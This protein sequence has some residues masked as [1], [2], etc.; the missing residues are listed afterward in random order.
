MADSPSELGLHPA[1]PT[2]RDHRPRRKIM[3]LAVVG[4]LL[5][6][7]PAAHAA[8]VYQTGFEPPGYSVGP[9]NRQ[10]GWRFTSLAQVQTTTVLSGS[11][12]VSMDLTAFDFPGHRFAYDSSAHPGDILQIKNN[13]FLTGSQTIQVEGISIFGGPNG[14]FLGQLADYDSRFELGLAGST[15]VGSI[16]ATHDVWHSLELDINFATQTQAAFVDGVFLVQGPLAQPA[17]TFTFVELG[18][19]GTPEANETVSYDD[20]SISTFVPEPASL[21]LLGAGLAGLGFIRHRRA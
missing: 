15:T 21:A 14:G 17:T 5:A 12:A 20:F 13:I 18:G 9:L 16:P 2:P 6:G 10:D 3:R 1:L 19:F 8:I 11:Q 4:L 7:A